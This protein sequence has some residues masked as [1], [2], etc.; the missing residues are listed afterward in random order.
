M[1]SNFTQDEAKILVEQ[2]EFVFENVSLCEKEIKTSKSVWENIFPANSEQPSICSPVFEREITVDGIP[3]ILKFE[4]AGEVTYV[5]A[6]DMQILNDESKRD[7]L[8]RVYN[9]YYWEE[10]FCKKIENHV[11]NGSAVSV[12]IITI[13]NFAKIKEEHGTNSAEQLLCYV[14][15]QWKR[16]YDEGDE[17]VVCRLEENLFVIGCVGA[18]GDDLEHQLRALYEKMNL[19]CTSTGGMLCRIPFTLSIASACTEEVKAPNWN[20]LAILCHARHG[21]IMRLGGNSV[22]T[23]LR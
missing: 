14:A 2:L 9:G 22:A 20:E 8:S 6:R 4:D 16:F 11:A 3:H 19:V 21:E 5:K 18:E 13:D 1:K 15:N 12:A 17:K 23:S 7:P 10:D